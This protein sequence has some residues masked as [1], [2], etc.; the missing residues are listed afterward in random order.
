MKSI[1]SIVACAVL[2][3]VAPRECFALWDVMLVSKEEAKGLGLEVRTTAAGPNHVS[4]ELE[5][6]TEGNFK[7]F[8]PDGKYKD[9]SGVWLWIGQG[10]TPHLSAALKEDRSKA[11]SVV[12][13]FTAD[14][15][16]LDQ[17]NLRVLAPFQDGGAGGTEYRLLV[18]DFVELKKDR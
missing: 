17:S 10:D 13:G 15:V 5:F 16:Q 14:R 2:L 8:S 3:G 18:K 11:G 4:V 12:V 6:K 1:L 9:R 7:A